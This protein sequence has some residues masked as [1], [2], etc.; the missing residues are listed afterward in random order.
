[1]LGLFRILVE[2][3]FNSQES[4]MENNYINSPLHIYILQ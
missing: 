2:G 3:S 4:T 1:M